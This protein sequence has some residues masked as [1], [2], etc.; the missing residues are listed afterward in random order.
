VA[1]GLIAVLSLSLVVAGRPDLSDSWLDATRRFLRP[2]VVEWP[3]EPAAE[4]RRTR[5]QQTA[6]AALAYALHVLGVEP[7]HAE[8]DESTNLDALAGAAR[9]EGLLAW[10]QVLPLAALRDVPKPVVA[11]LG[12]DRYVVVLALEGTLVDLFDP[13]SGYH[14][15][16]VAAL[17]S[18]WRGEVVV[19]RFP[20]LDVPGP[21]DR[22]GDLHHAPSIL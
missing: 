20:P 18:V 21:L 4:F 9:R 19:I 14:Q 11:P 10:R 16:A 2:A 1:G 8:L 15:V 12:D 13:G 17:S 22:Q 5:G 6:G 7:G 3:R